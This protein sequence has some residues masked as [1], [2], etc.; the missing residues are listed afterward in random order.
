MLS[1]HIQNGRYQDAERIVNG[2]NV[3]TVE[4]NEV[5]DS[6]VAAN[7]RIVAHI[8]RIKKSEGKRTQRGQGGE[9]RATI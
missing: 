1:R 5:D 9:T 6:F 2:P 4:V 3:R 8:L 7:T